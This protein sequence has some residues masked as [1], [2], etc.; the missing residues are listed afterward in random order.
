MSSELI[1]GSTVRL[2]GH[3]RPFS[4]QILARSHCHASAESIST[5]QLM[6][7]ATFATVITTAYSSSGLSFP[8]ASKQPASVH[9]WLV[10]PQSQLSK[11]PLG[12]G[13]RPMR[14]G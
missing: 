11:A 14:P 5:R 13:W 12:L 4:V 1:A 8:G 2:S 7:P 9:S 6:C 10:R 3:H